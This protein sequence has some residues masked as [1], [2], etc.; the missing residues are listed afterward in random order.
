MRVCCKVFIRVFIKKCRSGLHVEHHEHLEGFPRQ[1]ARMVASRRY[2]TVDHPHCKT[3]LLT[4]RFLQTLHIP[5]KVFT[6][7]TL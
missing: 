2:P 7:F 4:A 5:F 6:V 1:I 3:P